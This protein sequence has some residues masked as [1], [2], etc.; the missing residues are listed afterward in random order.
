MK[1]YQI[2]F[3]FFG[4]ITVA[5]AFIMF[6]WMPD[7]PT[8]AKFLTDEDKIIAIERLRNNQMGVMSREWRTPHVVEAL[9]DLKTWYWVAMIFCISVPS[10][11]ISTFGPLI[12]KSFV[13]DPFETMLFN[14]PVGI[15]HIIAV[16]ASAY[17]S[18][19]WK[20]KGPVIAMLC[21]PPI[22]GCAILLHFAHSLENKAACLA[23][24]F[25]LCTFTGITP[26]IYSWSAQNTAG[27]TKRKTTSALIFISASAGNI[28]GPLLYSPDEAPA[29]T[30]GLRANLAFY[31]LIVALVAGT[32]LH[33]SRLNRLHSQ[34]RV[35]LGKS[36]VLVDR[37]LET[38]EEVERIEHMER[39]LRG[40]VTLREAT[41]DEH[42][43]IS[44]A[45]DVEGERT[46]QKD[47]DKGFGDTTDLENED[48]LF[49]F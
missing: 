8:E 6:F 40:G 36:A 35:A 20:L 4:A 5:V 34:R 18:M 13:S 44:Q 1:P 33:L 37:S 12:I 25:C 28:V 30:R 42:D 22:A 49:V 11:G 24:Y 26:L 48:F 45:H 31:V 29:Y 47:G 46:E 7:S 2:I 16:S 21:V 14:V 9:K 15:S 3:L 38:A 17:V 27:D 41:G 10:N 32:S 19:K 43:R 23:G 39:T